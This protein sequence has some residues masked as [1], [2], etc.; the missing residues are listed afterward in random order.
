MSDSL[1]PHG[2]QP[3]RLLCPWDFPGKDTGVGFHLLLQGVF[4]TQ[5]SH[6]GL[7]CCRQTLYQLSHKGSPI[8]L[9][10]RENLLLWPEEL[11]SQS[12][13]ENPHSFSSLSLCHLTLEV[14]ASAESE[15]QRDQG[16]KSLGE[17]KC[18]GHC[19]KKRAEEHGPMKLYMNF[20]PCTQ[21]AYAWILS[22]IPKALRAIKSITSQV[23]IGHLLTHIESRSD[24]PIRALEKNLSWNQ[25]PHSV[26]FQS[27]DNW[28]DCLLKQH[29]PK[30]K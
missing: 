20:C 30:Q 6:P 3:T 18:W 1:W 19:G 4:P 21:A 13:E 22:H 23:P 29:N 14:D 9:G 28:L 11:W 26:G 16:R 7:P 8:K 10:R 15:Q 5:G 17:E 27:E 2:L 24:W 12:H 25:N